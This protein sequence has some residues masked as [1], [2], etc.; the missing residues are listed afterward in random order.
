MGI[1]VWVPTLFVLM[2]YKT[3]SVKATELALN[4]TTKPQ[5]AHDLETGCV[6]QVAHGDALEIPLLS[7]PHPE[8]GGGKVPVM[9][10]GDLVW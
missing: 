10:E 7:A 6:T 1:S 9:Q 5:H 4:C 3:L 2:L 8:T